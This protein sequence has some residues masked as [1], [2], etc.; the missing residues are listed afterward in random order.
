MYLDWLYHFLVHYC[1]RTET[2]SLWNDPAFAASFIEHERSI[3][4]ASAIKKPQEPS[5]EQYLMQA[6]RKLQKQMHIVVVIE[7]MQSYF[8]WVGLF[9]QMEY[10]FEVAYM[11]DLSNEGYK[12]VTQAYLSN[13]ESDNSIFAEAKLTSAIV[14]LKQL[15]KNNVLQSFYSPQMLKHTSSDDYMVTSITEFIMA[16]DT[17]LNGYLFSDG[18]FDLSDPHHRTYHYSLSVPTTALNLSRFISFLELFR[19]LFDYLSL[20]LLVRRNY[21]EAFLRKAAEFQRFFR[22]IKVRK[23]DLGGEGMEIG[24]RVA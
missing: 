12:Q 21:Y 24:M 16:S 6:M 3:Y 4:H 5:N 8:E 10:M 1:N 7:D 18:L 23:G 11:D 17:K 20:S 2:F 15:V 13:R 14:E 19:Y 22:D 9:P